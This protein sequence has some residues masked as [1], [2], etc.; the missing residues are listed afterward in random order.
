[1][2]YKT[3]KLDPASAST[4]GAVSLTSCQSFSINDTAEVTR[5]SSDGKVFIQGVFVS[6]RGATVTVES[7]DLSLATA[8]VLTPGTTGSLILKG[9]ARASGSGVGASIVYTFANA[10][11]VGTNKSANTNGLATLS[12]TFEVY[13]SDGDANYL[14]VS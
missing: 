12:I 1:M 14:V 11:T 2:A 4:F 6:A 3:Y 8:T 10:V 7:Q 9:A 13:S 5:A